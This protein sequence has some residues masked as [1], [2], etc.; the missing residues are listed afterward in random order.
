MNQRVLC[1]YS[2]SVRVG[3]KVCRIKNR[4]PVKAVVIVAH[5]E[6][7][8]WP[9]GMIHAC[10]DFIVV[11]VLGLEKR[12]GPTG[13]LDR[14]ALQCIGHHGVD[15]TTG[16]RE[17]SN[18][19]LGRYRRG[20]GIP[21][22][23]QTRPLV[24]CEEERFIP[25]NGTSNGASKLVSLE[26]IP[27]HVFRRLSVGLRQGRKEISAVKYGIAQKLEEVAVKAVASR[28]GDDVYNGPGVLTVLRAIVARLH[29]EFLKG[30]GK[31]ERLVDVGVLIHVIAAVQLIT[32]HVLARPVSRD[33]HR[34]RERLG[35]A[36][37]G[38]SA[39]GIVRARCQESELCCVAAI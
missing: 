2:G 9:D 3:K 4:I 26:L 32:D 15:R 24:A 34:T 16:R 21:Y 7:I 12:Y 35:E 14:Q 5:R 11:I 31:R 17:R 25:S 18:I 19:G 8:G 38:P 10:Y 37:V 33:R 30:V 29:A 36:L 23:S 20:R 1:R 27:S 39:R 28:L 22:V 6:P 13:G